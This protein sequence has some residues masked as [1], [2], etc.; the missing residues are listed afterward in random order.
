MA[1]IGSALAAIGILAEA[2]ELITGP[3]TRNM[4]QIGLLV[5]GN[6]LLLII[7]GFLLLSA[8]ADD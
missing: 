8:V 7:V 4:G 2:F 5:M 6:G 1:N 3:Q